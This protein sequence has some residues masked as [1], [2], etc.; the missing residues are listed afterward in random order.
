M[1]E[2]VDRGKVRFIGVSNFSVAELRKAQ[3]ALSR[4]R[5]AS[6]QV[7]YRSV[8]GATRSARYKKEVI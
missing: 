4:H 3:A 6:N 7:S 8:A 5:I 1:E 2:L